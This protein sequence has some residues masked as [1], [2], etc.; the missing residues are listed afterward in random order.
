MLDRLNG[1]EENTKCETLRERTIEAIY[2][3]AKIEDELDE[4]YECFEVKT[5]DGCDYLTGQLK[6]IDRTEVQWQAFFTGIEGCAYGSSDSCDNAYEISEDLLPA[7]RFPAFQIALCDRGSTEACEE[8]PIAAIPTMTLVTCLGFDPN[9]E[10]D[11]LIC[12][13]TDERVQQSMRRLAY[14]N[15]LGEEYLLC[16]RENDLEACEDLSD[17]LNT[18]PIGINSP[19]Q[20]T[21]LWMADRV[22]GLGETDRCEELVTY[23]SEHWDPAL[24][25]DAFERYCRMEVDDACMLHAQITG[26]GD[27][28]PPRNIYWAEDYFQSRPQ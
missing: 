26:D 27:R 17:P 5:G 16:F 21:N 14:A 13:E 12:A 28:S 25:V 3:T 22:C 10:R 23:V 8:V 4:Y 9:I 7:E 2:K 11:N 19:A 24:F 1:T 20:G 18:D 15:Y 6:K